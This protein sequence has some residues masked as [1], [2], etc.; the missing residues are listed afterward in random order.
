MEIKPIWTETIDVKPYETDFQNFWKPSNFFQAMQHISSNH[1]SS[2]GF[3]WK[4]LMER[5]QAWVLSR[6][7]IY[8][9]NYPAAGETV[10][11]RTWPKGIQQKLFFIRDFELEYPDGQKVASASTAWLLINPKT[12][13]LLSP[14]A[15][16][17][18]LPENSGR[19]ALDETLNKINPP[20]D[21]P[22]QHKVQARYSALDLMGHVNN[23]RYV[24]WITDSFSVEDYTQRKLAWLQINYINEVKPGETVSICLDRQSGLGY[25][26]NLDAGNKSFEMAL[27]WENK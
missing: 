17:S 15:L 8:F 25:G 23:A 4:F 20:E 16:G 3:D 10:V 5:D 2:L 6:V 12:R 26:A 19:F 7:K 9:W 13:R 27:G 11:V 1:S 22:E 14:Q 21:L 18:N 24:E